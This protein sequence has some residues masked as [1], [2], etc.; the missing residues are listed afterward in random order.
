MRDPVLFEAYLL[1]RSLIIFDGPSSASRTTRNGESPS[2]EIII[3]KAFSRFIL[4][5]DEDFAA[6]MVTHKED[7]PPEEVIVSDMPD[8]FDSTTFQTPLTRQAARMR[9]RHN[10]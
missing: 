8:S 10:P 3:S 4:I 6:E 9:N 2:A 1:S 7:T 5:D